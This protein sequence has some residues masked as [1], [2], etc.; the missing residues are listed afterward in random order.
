MVE[1]GLQLN[2]AERGVEEGAARTSLE[3]AKRALQEGED[4]ITQR[5]K[6]MKVADRSELG[7]A[8]VAEY[9]DQRRIHGGRTRGTC[10]PPPFINS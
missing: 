3:N 5:Q 8:V 1:A 7:W 2:R 4:L 9:Q 6:L 10:P